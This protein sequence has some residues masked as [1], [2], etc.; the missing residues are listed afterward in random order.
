MFNFQKICLL[1][2]SLLSS[3]LIFLIRE[4]PKATV[5]RMKLILHPWI[6]TELLHSS[7]FSIL[8]GTGRVQ[9]LSMFDF[10]SDLRHNNNKR[11]TN[12]NAG[13]WLRRSYENLAQLSRHSLERRENTPL[14]INMYYTAHFACDWRR[15]I[16][17]VYVQKLSIISNA[18]FHKV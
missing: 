10:K 15:K 8:N 3:W 13:I 16:Q 9:E 14:R 4:T 17:I 2:F 12:Q 1:N 7:C 18:K 11:T 5:R 6:S